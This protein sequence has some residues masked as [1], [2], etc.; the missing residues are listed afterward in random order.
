MRRRK[1]RRW[2]WS[3]RVRIPRRIRMSSDDEFSPRKLGEDEL[4]EW[5]GALHLPNFSQLPNRIWLIE[6]KMQR[7]R[8]R[9]KREP[10][11]K[12]I[13]SKHKRQP[14]PNR[15]DDHR[16]R[17]QGQ[18]T[19]ELQRQAGLSACTEDLEL[20]DSPASG[21]SRGGGISRTTSLQSSED[22][23]DK[24]AEMFIANFYRQLKLERQV[25]LQLRYCRG[26]SFDSAS[27]THTP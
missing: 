7:K 1:W 16:S 14:I 6:A 17:S 26:D 18:A 27:P 4:W 21:S 11:R 25:S 10:S 3:G 19:G 8:R 22:D 20:L 12:Y 5:N 2:Y 9:R 13:P 23:I 15:F 24:R